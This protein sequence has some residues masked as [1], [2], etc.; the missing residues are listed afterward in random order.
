MPTRGTEKAKLIAKA[1]PVRSIVPPT[2]LILDAESPKPKMPAVSAVP[3]AVE[4]IVIGE[5]DAN[6]MMAP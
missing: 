1:A 4:V 5:P 3:S 6:G 2:A